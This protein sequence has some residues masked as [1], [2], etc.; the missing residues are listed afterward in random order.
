MGFAGQRAIAV[1][2]G[3]YHSLALTADG[4]VWSWGYGYTGLLGHGDDE[5]QP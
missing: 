3:G 4:A 5:H 1:S 2:L